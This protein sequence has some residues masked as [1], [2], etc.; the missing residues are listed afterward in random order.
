MNTKIFG[1]IIIAG[2]AMS[3]IS[4][5]DFLDTTPTDSVSD[6]TIWGKYEYAQLHAN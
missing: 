2:A 3:L 4:C 1:S 5:S 6:K